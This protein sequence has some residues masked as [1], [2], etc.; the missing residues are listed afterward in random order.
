[1]IGIS[2]LYMGQIE[3]S[4]ALRY[5]G[6]S[7]RLPSHLLQFSTDKK[8]VVIWNV[9]KKCNLSCRHCYAATSATCETELTFEEGKKLTDDLS[10]L[11]CPVIL[12][13]GGEPLLAEESAAER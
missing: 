4:D 5:G 8:P 11:G 7:A 13:S 1:M 2:K 3:A 6:N 9:T 12:F 10:A